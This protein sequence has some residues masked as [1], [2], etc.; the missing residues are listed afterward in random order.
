MAARRASCAT[1]L[2]TSSSGLTGASQPATVSMGATLLGA[3]WIGLGLGHLLLIRDLDHGVLAI[4]TVL[5]AV[6]A[7]DTFAFFA[8]RLVGRHR[9]APVMSPRKT[10]EGFF[11]GAAAAVAV[12]FFA[13]YPDRDDFLSLAV[14]R[15]GRRP[16]RRRGARRP[17]RVADQAGHGRQGHG[18]HHGRARRHARPRR[19]APLGRAGRVLLHRGL[20]TLGAITL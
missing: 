14:A 11:V 20:A 6:F 1:M 16:G 17:L 5:I 4:F 18:P 8:G 13:I 19:R 2:L 3:A 7:A 9:L 10:W 12:S 15:A